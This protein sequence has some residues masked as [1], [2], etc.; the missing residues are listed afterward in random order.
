[1]F[2]K[3]LLI[4][5]LAAT[6]ALGTLPAAAAQEPSMHEIYL[7]A[8][9]GRFI[10]AQTMMD[11]VLKE[12]PNSAKAHYVQAELQAK[13]GLVAKAG[14]ELRTAERLQPG[15]AFAKPEAVEKL[16]AVI[17][18][19]R[20]SL[21]STPSSRSVQPAMVNPPAAEKGLP[22]GLLLGGAGLVAFIVFATRFMRQRNQA[23]MVPA[24]AYAGYGASPG[25][26]PP[27]GF[28]RAPTG[29]MM[30]PAYGTAPAYGAAPAPAAGGIG[31][32]IMGG[33]ATG[34][35][36]GAGIVAGQAL[37]HHFTDGDRN[38]NNLAPAPAGNNWNPEP[39]ND[40]GGNDFGVNDS[41][42]W[43]DGGSSSGGG[44]DWN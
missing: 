44:D 13:Q 24:G 5:A 37:M 41:S 42:S 8:E 10:E 29:P 40:M 43:D 33:L 18:A 34:A 12:H 25:M 38:S 7:A 35:A 26:Q 19:P 30:A 16:R 21:Q 27:Q 3:F 14:A 32:G 20:T 11:Q 22:W 6:A 15:L 23:A 31:S 36:V 17:A 4:L 2:K 9:G 39:A 1:M 28:G